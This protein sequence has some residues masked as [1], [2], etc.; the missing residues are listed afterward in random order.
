MPRVRLALIPLLFAAV[1]FLPVASPAGIRG[2]GILRRAY[3]A[4]AKQAQAYQQAMIAQ[5]AAMAKA[6]AEADAHRKEM[7]RE[8][9]TAE[10]TAKEQHRA[11]TRDFYKHNHTIGY[12]P[13]TVKAAPDGG[14]TAAKAPASK[15]PTSKAPVKKPSATTSSNSLKK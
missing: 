10:K 5:Q 4:Q 3:E 8:A 12:N 2:Y 1:A 13:D 11:A 14:T 6:Q 15:V 9:H 7:L